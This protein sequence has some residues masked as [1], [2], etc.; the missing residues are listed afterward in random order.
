MAL[1][2]TVWETKWWA[3]E[4]GTAGGGTTGDAGLPRGVVPD[5]PDEPDLALTTTVWE[6]KWWAT[7]PGTKGSGATRPGATRS[8]TPW[9]DPL[10]LSPT[11]PPSP[12]R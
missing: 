8:W 7:K 2:T 6:T 4:P 1:T 12:T 3:T 11:P 5:L 9:D 10:P